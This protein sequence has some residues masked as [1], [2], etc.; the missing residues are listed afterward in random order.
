MPKIDA[1]RR[2]ERRQQIMR[3]ARQG[4]RRKSYATLT[5][6]DICAE[7]GLSKGAFYVHFES[8][9]ALLAALIDD[10]ADALETLMVELE[11]TAGQR[12]TGSAV[13][14][15]SSSSGEPTPATPKPAPTPSA[16]CSTTATLGTS[17]TPRYERERTARTVDRRCRE[18]G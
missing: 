6:D 7:A 15:A 10:D 17:S 4:L 11:A 1:D 13:S 12:A 8:K 9:Q 16:K 14:Y 18:R 3:G 2:L 5:V